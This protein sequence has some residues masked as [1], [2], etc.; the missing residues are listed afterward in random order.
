MFEKNFS[1]ICERINNTY[2]KNK[3]KSIKF[4]KQISFKMKKTNPKKSPVKKANEKGKETGDM[5]KAATLKPIKEKEK[6]NWK[7]S[8]SEDDEDFNAEEG[9]ELDEDFDDE[10]YDKEDEDDGFYDEN[11]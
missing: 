3:N 11:Y 1:E 9:M 5:K 7:N 10:N 6:Q 4:V 8:L 2:L